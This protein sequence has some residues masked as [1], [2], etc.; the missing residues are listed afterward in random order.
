MRISLKNFSEYSNFGKSS[1]VGTL[2]PST[3][4]NSL[5]Y[6]ESL[7]LLQDKPRTML[8]QLMWYRKQQIEI[9]LFHL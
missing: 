7:D 9:S 1:L 3:E 5:V 8:E 4:S 2:L 6:L